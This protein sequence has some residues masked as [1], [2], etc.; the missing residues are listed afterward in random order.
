MNIYF[1]DGVNQSTCAHTCDTLEEAKVWVSEQLKGHTLVDDDRKCTEDVMT[2]SKTAQYQVYDG[3][4]ITLGE[5]G[6]PTFASIIYESDYFY[7]E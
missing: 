6:E 1:N 3:E 2:S 7:T 4:L 5:D